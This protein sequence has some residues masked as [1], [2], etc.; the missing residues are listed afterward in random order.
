MFSRRLPENGLSQGQ[1][2][3]FNVIFMPNSLNNG[4]AD[5][6]Y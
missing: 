5:A 6:D 4:K 3:A 1:N 2:L